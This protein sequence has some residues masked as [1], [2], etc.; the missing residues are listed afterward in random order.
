MEHNEQK[1]K[2]DFSIK[3]AWMGLLSYLVLITII[4]IVF[5]H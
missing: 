5:L 4:T 3:A 2:W 1:G